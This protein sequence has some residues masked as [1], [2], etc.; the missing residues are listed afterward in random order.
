MSAGTSEGARE[1]SPLLNGRAL[2]TALGFSSPDGFRAAARGGRVPVPLFKI[3]GRQGW[4][5]RTADV[6]AWLRSIDRDVAENYPPRGAAP[7]G[8]GQTS[9]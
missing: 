1:P 2:R 5:A 3:P 8:G 6:A 9:A 7:G 4:F